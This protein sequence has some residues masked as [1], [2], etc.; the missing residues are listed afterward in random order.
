MTPQPRAIFFFPGQ[1]TPAKS[2]RFFITSSTVYGLSFT[3]YG[4]F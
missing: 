4:S 1:K 2:R 3:V